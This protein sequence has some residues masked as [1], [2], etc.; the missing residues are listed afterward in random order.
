MLVQGGELR[1]AALGLQVAMHATNITSQ[2]HSASAP[3][4]VRL[5]REEVQKKTAQQVTALVPMLHDVDPGLDPIHALIG[6]L[7]TL[8]HIFIRFSEYKTFPTQLW[9][10]TQAFNAAGYVK[11]IDSFL[12]LPQEALDVGYSRELQRAALSQ[13]SLLDGVS[14]MMSDEVQ[15]ELQGLFTTAVGTSLDVERK[16]KQDKAGETTRMTTCARGSR[17][18]ILQRYRL[19]RRIGVKD[20]LVIRR[21]EHKARKTNV[22]ALAVKRRPDLLARPRGALHWERRVSSSS[23][24]STHHTGDEHAL[25]AFISA[26]LTSLEQERDRIKE[27]ALRLASSSPMPLTNADWLDWLSHHD[28]EFQDLMRTA[29][30]KRRALNARLTPIADLRCAPRVQPER[31]QV[32]VTKTLQKLTLVK[33]GF[34]LVRYLG[35]DASTKKSAFFVC[36]LKGECWGMQLQKSRGSLYWLNH[37][38]LLK[39]F[40]P[41]QEVA[42][43]EGIDL[44]DDGNEVF[45]LECSYE[46][47][48]ETPLLRLHE[49]AEVHAPTQAKKERRRKK[50][51][52]EHSDVEGEESE[53]EAE[54]CHGD[55]DIRSVVSEEESSA[56]EAIERDEPPAPD[57][58]SDDPPDKDLDKAKEKIH[59]GLALEEDEERG[60]LD[61]ERAGK[62]SI[63]DMCSGYFTVTNNPAFSDV[64]AVVKARWA[65]DTGMGSKLKSKSLTPAHYGEDKGSKM[66]RTKCLLNA[67]MIHKFQEGGFSQA[68]KSRQTWL[69]HAIESLR[70]DV[71]AL[72]SSDGLLG[73]DLANRRLRDWAPQV[74]TA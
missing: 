52:V 21:V 57:T 23:R 3:V 51:R 41:F 44:R 2:I 68:N 9:T 8:G 49:G 43:A 65:T 50:A 25:K 12:H 46:K 15:A 32:A 37:L 67:W 63:P 5:G 66:P 28:A 24:A 7:T 64:R 71:V 18:A 58:D 72:D 13:G 39:D 36:T 60:T 38:R 45:K 70:R 35:E 4:L 26:N 31:E 27:A 47:F 74:V 16:H 10:L 55:S 11:A 56:A 69:A 34:V 19:Q 42:Q 61:R 53:E 33:Q 6:L 30:D 1:V 22:R 17:N 54:G 73:N 29:T 40:R 20:R 48:D 59:E 14:Y 62:W